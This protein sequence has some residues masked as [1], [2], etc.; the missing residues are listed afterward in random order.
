[1]IKFIIETVTS[2]RDVNGNCYHIA[3]ITR[4]DNRE[5]FRTDVGGNQNAMYYARKAGLEFDEVYNVQCVVAK[6]YFKWVSKDVRYREPELEAFFRGE[7][8][9]EHP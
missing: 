3:V 1:M 7:I 5:C 8:K 2:S 9:G 6:R 4:T